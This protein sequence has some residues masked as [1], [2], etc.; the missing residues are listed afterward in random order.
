[1]P[2]ILLDNFEAV[3]WARRRSASIVDLTGSAPRLVREGSVAAAELR[4]ELL[5][6]G[7]GKLVVPFDVPR[8]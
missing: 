6:L 2:V 4:A 8:V 1:V 3:P 5:R 7:L